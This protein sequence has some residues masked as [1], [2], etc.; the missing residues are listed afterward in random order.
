MHDLCC[1]MLSP[2]VLARSCVCG[3]SSLSWSPD[4]VD[5]DQDGCWRH[6]GLAGELRHGPPSLFFLFLEGNRMSSGSVATASQ[7]DRRS[8]GPPTHYM[9][10]SFLLILRMGTSVSERKIKA[11][12]CPRSRE[13][14]KSWS[15]PHPGL[16]P[17]TPR[18][19]AL[20]SLGIRVPHVIWPSP[21][22]M[23]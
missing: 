6:I 20:C 14:N 13:L 7:L 11:Y 16:F 4:S 9:P 18:V 22:G 17:R 5:Q 21:H 2:D 12:T 1:R 10:N 15:L 3:R 8:W 19:S 23:L